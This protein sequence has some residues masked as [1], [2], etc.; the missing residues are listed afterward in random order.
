MVFTTPHS[1]NLPY[2]T[3][4][5][6]N[7]LKQAKFNTKIMKNGLKDILEQMEGTSTVDKR[8]VSNVKLTQQSKS[9]SK[10]NDRKNRNT[11]EN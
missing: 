1:L 3:V 10:K 9:H 8:R 2:C 5:T 6:E 11:F 7:A 4:P